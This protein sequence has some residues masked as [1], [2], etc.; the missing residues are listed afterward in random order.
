MPRAQAQTPVQHCQNCQ[1]V[2]ERKRFNGRLEDLTVFKKR[3]FCNQV[4]MAES[5]IQEEVTLAGLRSRS[6]KL[7][8]GQCSQCGTQENLHVHHMDS[9]PA[10]NS[11]GNLK[12]LCAACHAKWHWEHGK[13]QSKP[14][15]ACQ[16]CDKPARK[17]GLCNTHASRMYRHGNPLMVRGGIQNPTSDE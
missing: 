3:K 5:M 2:L 10:N 14:V 7:K 4:C 9:N 11:S 12:T 15:K 13:S 16:Y 17:N 8:E 6:M 1:K